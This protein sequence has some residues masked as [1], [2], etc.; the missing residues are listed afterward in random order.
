M[1]FEFL[2][3]FDNQQY[4]TKPIN[5]SITFNQESQEPKTLPK[6]KRIRDSKACHSSYMRRPK[7][8]FEDENG[9]Y[10]I[11]QHDFP[12]VFDRLWN[13]AETKNDKLRVKRAAKS[14]DKFEMM[15]PH[16]T[17]LSSA[18]FNLKD[19]D[20]LELNNRE[21]LEN[22]AIQSIIS[23]NMHY[24]H[25]NNIRNDYTLNEM[26]NQNIMNGKLSKTNEYIKV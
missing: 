2:D 23:Q 4:L 6:P 10:L 7:L 22:Q 18:H 5:K 25:Q 11:F 14:K 12:K 1:K 3:E 19:F 16:P 26:R 21:A 8:K 13:D 17:D 9:E 20:N 24:I 15:N